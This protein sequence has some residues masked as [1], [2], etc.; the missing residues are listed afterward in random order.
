MSWR[1]AILFAAAFVFAGFVLRCLA[2]TGGLWTDEAWSVVYARQAGSL[3]GI[4]TRINH[5]NNHHLNSLWLLIVGPDASPL[6]MRGLSILT[7]TITIWVAALIGFRRNR[8]AGVF[9]AA[10]FAVSPIMLIYGS[11]ARGYAPMIFALM[12]MIWRIDVWLQNQSAPKPA[13]M[14]AFWALLGSFSH[15][16]MVPA[17]IML[18]AWVFMASA[19]D[20]GY[21]KSLKAS[22]SL[23]GPALTVAVSSLI[24]VVWIASLAP[25]GLQIGGYTPFSWSLFGE[26]IA[27]LLTLSTGVGIFETFAWAMIIFA[28][29][30]M[31]IAT[32]RQDMPVDRIWFYV[33]LIASLPLAVAVIHP[34]NIQYARYY[35]A[36]AVAMI[37]L[38]AEWMGCFASKRGPM[39]IVVVVVLGATLSFSLLHDFD[40]IKRQRGHPERA[41]SAIAGLAARGTSITIEFPGPEAGLS[42]AA[43]ARDYPLRIKQDR[44]GTAP[45]HFTQRGHSEP[46]LRQPRNCSAAMRL[47]ASATASGPSG[48]SWAVYVRQGL[49]RAIAAVNRSPP[50]Q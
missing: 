10:L 40:F 23:M 27:S 11:E 28:V 8:P 5:D 46:V 3:F 14:L 43:A 7:S 18:A 15:L 25:T 47:I 16:T 42:V 44:C 13:A 9:A 41:I 29:I 34:G 30:L 1:S 45:F 6:I 39:R 37:I 4:L 20:Q 33:I 24:A 32:M 36:S 17:V 12:I 26:G 49:P 22:L 48:Q 35:L 38:M 50:R 21:S 2:A 31:M 19:A